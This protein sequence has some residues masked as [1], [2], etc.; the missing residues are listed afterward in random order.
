MQINNPGPLAVLAKRI[1]ANGVAKGFL[2]AGP[3]SVATHCA[4]LTGEVSE[5]WEAH[6]KGRLHEPSDHEGLDLMCGEEEIADVIIRALDFCAQ[7]GID[8]DYSVATKMRFNAT[9]PYRHGGKVA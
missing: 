4:N 9:R 7:N 1:L 2:D 6:R 3:I 5:L 8:P